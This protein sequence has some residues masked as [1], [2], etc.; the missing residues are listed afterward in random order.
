MER[1]SGV[2][3]VPLHPNSRRFHRVGVSLC[4]S[5]ETKTLCVPIANAIF[6][7]GDRVEGSGNPVIER[8]SNLQNLS[9]IVVTK[10]GSSINAWVIEASVFNGPFAVYKDFILSMNQYGEPSSY[11]PIDFP[12]STSTVS[13]LSNCLEEAKKVILGTQVDSKS[14]CTSACSFSQPETFILGFSK[15]GTV[16]NQIITELGFSDIG[17]NVNSPDVGSEDI[18]IVPKTNEDLLNSISDIHYVDVGLNTAGAYLTNHDVFE[19]ISKRLMQGAPQLR[20]ILHGTPRQW[21][22]KRRDWIRN[23]KDKMLHLLESEVRKSLGKIK[24]FSRYY[25]ADMPPSMQM[26]FEIIE[27]LDVS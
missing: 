21:S 20:F 15:G 11:N 9:E 4:L 5:P 22:D 25:F 18:Y 16:L 27:S 24:V 26:H 23:E 3:R 17:S 10:F 1:W 7:L 2:L 19:R 14:G 8:I 13:L 6:F 12:A